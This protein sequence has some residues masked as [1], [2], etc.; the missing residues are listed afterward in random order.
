MF[1]LSNGRLGR[2]NSTDGE[3]GGLHDGI[4]ASTHAG[5]FRDLV[6][7]DDVELEFLLDDVFLYF[8]G[9]VV[10][11]FIGTIQTIE[12]ESAAQLG[13]FEHIHAL[14]EV[15]LMTGDKGCLVHLNEIRRADGL[16]PEAQVRY[17]HCAGLLRVVIEIALREVVG[18][19][20][21]DLDRVLVRADRA[22]ST[23]TEEHATHGIFGL[24]YEGRVHIKAGV[25]DIVV[26]TNTEMILGF[27]FVQFIES[28]FDHC[29]SELFGR[30]TVTPTDDFDVCAV[31]F[32]KCG[33]YI[34]IEGFAA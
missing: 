9:K 30:K 1:D 22:I 13:I 29:G 24:D 10:P 32:D 23:E 4:H 5:L 28:G 16:R 21:D 26:D 14:K 33:N 12:Q 7:I 3:K 25:R 34:Q 17:R 20:A 19:F 27:R 11:N 15:E 2:Q 18:L 31:A 6:T 8:N